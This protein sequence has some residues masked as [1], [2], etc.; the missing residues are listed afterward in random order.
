M[1]DVAQVRILYCLCS[2]TVN[3]ASELDGVENWTRSL[4]EAPLRMKLN[5]YENDDLRGQFL[6]EGSDK[7]N[8]F[9]CQQFAATDFRLYRQVRGIL[10]VSQGTALIRVE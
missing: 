2:S 4:D 1:L 9:Y 5:D 10:L 7:N 3:G 6:G 8:Y